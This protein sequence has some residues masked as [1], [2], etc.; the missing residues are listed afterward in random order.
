MPVDSPPP[1]WERVLRL[2]PSRQADLLRRLR[3]HRAVAG[4]EQLVAYVVLREPDNPL[5]A[6]LVDYL[7]RRLPAAAVPA[8]FAVLAELPTLPS[9]K[10]DRRQL[11]APTTL[12]GRAADRPYQPPRTSTERSLVRIWQEVLGRSG[13]GVHDDI[14]AA[15]GSSL[16]AAQIVARVSGAGLGDLSVADVFADATVANLAARIDRPSMATGGAARG[17]VPLVAFPR[18]SKH[19]ASLSSAELRHWLLQQLDPQGAGLNVAA[20]VRIRGALDEPALRRA[21]EQVIERHEVLR[22]GY[23]AVDGLPVRAVVE[24][25]PLPLRREDV[26]AV[27]PASRAAALRRLIAAEVRRP[28]EL[29]GPPLLRAMLVD[30]DPAEWVLVLVAHHIVADDRAFQ[31]LFGELSGCYRAAVTGG[32]LPPPPPVQYSDY[33]VWESRMLGSELSAGLGYW[34][35]QLAGAP[36]DVTIPADPVGSEPGPTGSGMHPFL[37]DGEAVESLTAYVT[38]RGAT[39]F[40]AIL[41]EF[42]R[43]IAARAGRR[44]VVVGVPFANRIRPE[45]EQLVGCFINPAALRVDL[46]G[47][48]R[49]DQLLQRVRQVVIAGHR[50][51]HVPFEKVVERVVRHRDPSRPPLF[52]TVLNFMATPLGLSLPAAETSNVDLRDLLTAKYDLSLYVERATHGLECAMVYDAGRYRPE[53]VGDLADELVD[54]LRARSRSAPLAPEPRR[55]TTMTES[56]SGAATQRPVPRM[57]RRAVSIDPEHVV[58]REPAVPD[59]SLPLMLRPTAEL[60]L[61]AWCR[62]HR[63]SLEQDLAR[64]G[65]LL[66]RGFAVSSVTEFERFVLTFTD[67]VLN[68]VEGS[69]PRTMVVEK[70]YTSTEYPPEYFIS[71]HNEL[72]YA[73]KWPGKLFF[74]CEQP[75]AGGG[76]TPLADG[77]RVLE[78]LPAGLL[79]KFRERGVRYFRNLRGGEGPGLSWQAVFETDDPAWVESYCREGGITFEWTAGGGLRTCQVRPAV[80]RHPRTGEE[81]WFNQADQWHPSNL[82]EDLAEAM[83]SLADEPELPLNAQ[84]GDGTDFAPDELAQVRDAVRAAMVTVP[85]Q[86]GDILMIDNTMA[87]HG[88]MPFQGK[89]RVLVSMGDT[90][91]L[92]ELPAGSER[93]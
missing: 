13:I 41:A 5:P 79:A 57:R 3:E 72:S 89:R 50:Y 40:T 14:L 53:T 85:W 68:Y 64:H 38:G 18:G 23:P 78:L 37:V 33:A 70:V 77:R 76:E 36:T 88:R 46:S 39:P 51:Q 35:E 2:S 10:V 47:D 87:M 34:E 7:G 9:G 20:A 16:L 17:A 4:E 44:E 56:E 11:P 24:S 60:D 54:R 62:R 65:A 84:Y 25:V 29:A 6:D 52:S 81:V 58:A 71:L 8:H 55:G 49:H 66:F 42:A 43:S 21:W 26:R 75:A 27:P 86:A 90:V 69:S 93:S 92:G 82:G 63:Q 45:L 61:V 59:R 74:Y 1:L 73:H 31:V 19:R 83:V 67:D 80:V 28:F 91:H 22:T 12:D 30:I 15:G 32:P 48:L